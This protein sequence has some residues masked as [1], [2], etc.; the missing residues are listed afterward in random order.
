MCARYDR[1]AALAG[2][3]KEGKREKGYLESSGLANNSETESVVAEAGA[4]V[5]ARRRTA[6]PRSVVPGAAA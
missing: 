4:E 3:G 5:V 1:L 6:R 2:R